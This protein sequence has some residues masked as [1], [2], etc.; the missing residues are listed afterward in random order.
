MG[1][2]RLSCIVIVLEHSPGW[3]GGGVF[4]EGSCWRW[5][6]GAV[7]GQLL[8][9]AT[10]RPGGQGTVLRFPNVPWKAKVTQ[11]SERLFGRPG[12]WAGRLA[13]GAGGL[14]RAGW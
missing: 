5:P 13:S 2:L 4:V 14:R 7:R 8:K 1:K 12:E 6:Q 9:P 10:C 11:M 3:G